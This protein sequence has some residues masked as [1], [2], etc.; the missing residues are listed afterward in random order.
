MKGQKK[1]PRGLRLDRAVKLVWKSSPKWSLLNLVLTVFQG[2]LPL[3]G[4]YLMKGIVD[5]VALGLS[6]GDKT[7]AFQTALLWIVAAAAVAVAMAFCRSLSELAGEYLSQILTDSV[8]DILHS[9][10]LAVDLAYY[11]DPTFFDT[12]HRAQQEAPFRPNQIIQGLFQVGQNALSLMGVMVLLFSFNALLTFLLLC[13][14]LPT[15]LIRLIFARRSFQIEATLTEKERRA[16]YYH[17]L[18]TDPAPAKEVRLFFLGPIF[19]QRFREV[20]TLLRQGRM[21]F[22]GTRA[23]MDFLAQTLAAC[24]VFGSLIFIALQALNRT[25]TLGGL[26]I[27]YQGF[28][29][30]LNAFQ[31]LLRGMAGLYED[32]LFLDHFFS[33]LDLKPKQ[34]RSSP[35]KTLSRPVQE[36]VFSGVGFSYPQGK[37]DVLKDIH[38]TLRKGEVIALVGENGSGKT[39]LIK[40][41]CRLYD[42]QTGA[43]LVDGLDL[44]ELDPEAWKDRISVLFQ[45]YVHYYLSAAENIGLGRVE[46]LPDQERIREAAHL[47]GADTVINRLARG[48]DTPLGPWFE[49]GQEISSGEWQKIACA[50][51]FF[52]KG[53]ITVLDE[54]SSNLDPLAEAELFRRF[55]KIIEGRTAILISHRFSTVSLADRI[56]VLDRGRIVEQGTHEELLAC[57]G[58]YAALFEA[59]ARRYR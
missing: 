44:R 55:Q 7:A 8:S 59:Q 37:T 20:R 34:P 46:E 25:I 9:Q 58:R 45:D 6:T 41:L 5:S 17:F 4:I 22:Q 15:G 23:W 31:G 32:N 2:L 56:Y 13:A 1:I 50:R 26:V 14:A 12:L 43:I 29:L 51:A 28:Q 24:A 54:P 30:G 47:S 39:T 18:M 11:E 27:Y 36:I 21:A 16:W 48:Y 10:S 52:R 57:R 3:A 49:G 38:L 42:P 40:L 19:Q 33:F 35:A 53:E